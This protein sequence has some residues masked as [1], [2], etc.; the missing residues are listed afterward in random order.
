ML[1][2]DRGCDGMGGQLLVLPQRSGPAANA[3]HPMLVS[4]DGASGHPKSVTLCNRSRQHRQPL[5][6]W[7]YILGRAFLGRWWCEKQGT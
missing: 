6:T 1:N 2:G 3:P 7:C 4:S 5:L